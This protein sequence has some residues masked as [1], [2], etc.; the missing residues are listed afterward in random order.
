MPILSDWDLDLT[1]D[2][3][4]RGQGGDPAVLR[5][6]S[7]RLVQ[8]AEQALEEARPVLEP[9]VLYRLLEVEALRHERLILRQG[10]KLSG[11]LI[12]KHMLGAQ[13]VV[14]VLC[15]IGA[16]L[17]RRASEI[18]Q[19][20]LSLGL[21]LDG[22]GSAA[23]EALANAACDFFERQA[24]AEVLQTTIPLSPGMIGWLIEVGQREIFAL[25]NA[26]EIGV[27]LT[28]SILMKPR[29]SLSFALG[30]GSQLVESGRTCDYCN[31]RETCRYQDH[32]AEADISHSG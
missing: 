11:P 17:E 21:A 16:A 3:A 32:Y 28:D 30:L 13:K 4:L 8:V 10:G 29:K 9:R 24:A 26:S 6:R 1:V 14:V 19:E 15:T 2:H 7:P 27:E 25:V 18:F 31:L 22:L 5:L 20:D 12:A 23:V